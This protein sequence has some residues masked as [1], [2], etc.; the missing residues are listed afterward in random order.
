[1]TGHLT[2]T[3]IN[4]MSSWK[5]AGTKSE[6][7]IAHI[8]PNRRVQKLVNTTCTEIMQIFSKYL[9]GAQRIVMH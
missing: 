9:L 1:M 4:M 3:V 2:K 6:T 5:T 7:S 8:H